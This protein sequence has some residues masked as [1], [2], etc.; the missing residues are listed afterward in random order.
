MQAL[1]KKKTQWKEDLYF[2]MKLAWQ[3]LSKYYT[4]V[5]PTTGMLLISPHIHDPFWKM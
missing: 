4:E 5:T 1:A 3:K 2:A